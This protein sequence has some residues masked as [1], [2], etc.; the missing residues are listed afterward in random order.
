M[1]TSRYPQL[2]SGPRISVARGPVDYNP[3]RL[4]LRPDVAHG[5]AILDIPM[6]ASYRP[7]R[8]PACS[9]THILF[10]ADHGDMHGSHGM[11][12]KICRYEES[13]RTPFIISGCQPRYA[14]WKV[15]RLPVVSNHV[16]IAP[17]TLGLCG[18]RKP[19]WMEGADL[20]YHRIGPAPATP[21]PDSA[22]LQCVI[23]TGQADTPNTPYRGVVT[24]DGWKYVCFENQSWL[25]FNLNE[26]PYEEMN[27][28]QLDHYGPERKKL[29]SRLKQW[30][31]DTGDRFVVPEN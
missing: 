14:P 15:G 7:W 16:D 30:I 21:D 13:I 5:G 10:F 17:T 24:H 19:D 31:A 22:F 6:A 27:L 28:A 8:R 18:I 9:R 1:L 4:V 23:P 3:E 12:R 26:D 11:L 25:Q 20:S 2:R 29:I